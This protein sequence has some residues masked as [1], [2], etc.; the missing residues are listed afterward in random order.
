MVLNLSIQ[1]SVHILWAHMGTG[2]GADE[3]GGRADTDDQ[4]PY[5]KNNAKP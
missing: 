1:R 3:T 2:N 5:I 4:M